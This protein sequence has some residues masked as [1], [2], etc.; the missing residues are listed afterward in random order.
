MRYV[1]DYPGWEFFSTLQAWSD[2]VW[3]AADNPSGGVVPLY[4]K[5]LNGNSHLADQFTLM[6]SN[7]QVDRQLF[8]MTCIGRCNGG[9]LVDVY[10]PAGLLDNV[11]KEAKA[12]VELRPRSGDLEGSRI[13]G[14]YPVVRGDVFFDVM[15]ARV[16][17]PHN[18][19]AVGALEKV[20]AFQD[21]GVDV[22]ALGSGRGFTVKQIEEEL[23][24]RN[25]RA[26]GNWSLDD[27][28]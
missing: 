28:R 23:S 27:A 18:L 10:D 7:G 1:I 2:R 15:K 14:P 5:A 24:S 21:E 17:S 19:E 12:S 26:L 22:P 8:H 25:S 4:D 9:A 16:C 20:G 11:R 6:K 13:A 3:E